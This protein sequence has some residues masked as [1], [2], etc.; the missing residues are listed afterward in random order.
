MTELLKALIAKLETI[1][2]NKPTTNGQKIYEKAKSYIGTD[3]SPADEAPD[4]LG[5]ADSVT[6]I[7]QASNIQIPSILSTAKLFDTLCTTPGWLEVLSPIRGDIII[8]PTGKGTTGK[9][10][11]GHVGIMADSF[12]IMSNSSFTGKWEQNYTL[13]TWNQ[14]YKTLGGYPVYFFRRLG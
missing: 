2:Y 14:R 10:S 4:E 9:V 6:K 5:C 11:N 7:L 13:T 1:I 3:A 12:S 8:S